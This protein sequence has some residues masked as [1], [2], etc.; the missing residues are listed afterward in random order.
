MK[1]NKV[2]VYMTMIVTLMRLLY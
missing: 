2:I 1:K